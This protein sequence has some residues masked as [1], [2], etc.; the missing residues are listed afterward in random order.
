MNEHK[1]PFPL[2][3][4][5]LMFSSILVIMMTTDSVKSATKFSDVNNLNTSDVID[6]Y[7]INMVHKA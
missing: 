3:L 7:P 1:S 2:I 6:R 4:F 5:V